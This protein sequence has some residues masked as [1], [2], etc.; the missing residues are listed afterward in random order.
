MMPSPTDPDEVEDLF[1]R[2]A[3]LEREITKL[4]SSRGYRLTRRLHELA[5][6]LAP[7]DSLRRRAFAQ[8]IQGLRASASLKPTWT[9]TERPVFWLLSH[10]GG[11]GVERHV[12]DLAA[13]LR[14]EGVRPVLVRPVGGSTILWEE[15]DHRGRVVWRRKKSAARRAFEAMYRRHA[16]VH[17]HFHHLMGLPR[18]LPDWL[19]EWRL[20][21]DWT[22][23]DYFPICPRAH[24][25]R[26]SGTYCGEPDRAGCD[27]CLSRLGDYRGNSVTESITS[28]RDRFARQLSGA[29]RVFGPSEDV[30]RRLSR[31]YPRLDV[32]MRPHFETLP[33]LSSTITRLRGDETVRVLV[34]G[35]VVRVKGSERLLAC[36][37]DAQRRQLPLFFHVLGTTDCDRALAPL[38]NVHVSGS[39][40][41]D[42]VADR[43]AAARC[44]LAFVPS[45][46]PE[47]FMYTLSTAMAAGLYVVCFDLGAQAERVKSWGWG[48]VLP[49]AAQTAEINDSLIEAVRSLLAQS[50]PP[51][52]PR[53]ATY[54][55]LLR[56]Y[57]GFTSEDLI[58]L[59]LSPAISESKPRPNPHARRG[60]VHATL[61]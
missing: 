31:Y 51:A 3:E 19:A 7:V 13:A 8:A 36:A 25:H 10:Q 57:Y 49:I 2:I 37:R 44:Q 16:P 14:A 12:R 30:R 38:G 43:L 21:Y 15:L 55:S 39:Y 9:S 35:S 46:V 18:D 17:A 61:R 41:D 33:D 53:P 22:V 60:R 24:L 5:V 50:T 59:G 56:S 47:T 20:P 29:R 58:R 1:A 27:T 40:R 32:V 28:W 52:P 45:L 42:E 34:L 26:P 4:K 6:A 23:H 48:H 54:P 11:G